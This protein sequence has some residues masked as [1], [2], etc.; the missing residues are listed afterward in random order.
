[1]KIFYFL[2]VNKRRTVYEVECSDLPQK[3]VM[4]SINL[5]LDTYLTINKNMITLSSLLERP[6]FCQPNCIF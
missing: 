2:F 5:V 1:M 4:Q 3:K 6:T